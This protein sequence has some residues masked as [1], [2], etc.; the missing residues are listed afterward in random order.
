[1]DLTE[2]QWALIRPLIPPPP[3]RKMNRGRP[4]KPDRDCLNGILWVLRT[5]AQWKELPERYPPYQTCHRRFQEWV[6]QKTFQKILHRL[7][8]MLER[9]GKL[10]TAEQYIDGTFASAKKG[11]PGSERRSAEK[12]RR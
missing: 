8:R 6:R 9:R 5:G 3:S 1:M 10:R 2:A 4:R 7:A 12:A 11:G